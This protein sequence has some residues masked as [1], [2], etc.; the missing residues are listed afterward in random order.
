MASAWPE[1]TLSY[2]AFHLIWTLPVCLAL[3]LIN[4]PFLTKIDRAKLIL[5][6]LI[7]FVWTT[8]WD[9]LII[10]NQAWFYWR[11][12]VWFTIGYVPIEEYFFFI[13]QSIMTTLWCNL[14]TRWSM[15]NLYLS[16][17]PRSA[18]R[19]TGSLVVPPVAAA[20][21]VAGLRYAVPATHSYYMAMITWWSSIPLGLL[22]WG[23]IDFVFAMGAW[24]GLVPFGL[25]LLVPTVYLCAS[26]I[27]ALRRGTWHINER[28]S[29]NIFPVK[30]LPVE[31]M[32]FFLATNL[33]LV[34]ACFTFDRCVAIC[35]QEAD[36]IRPTTKDQKGNQLYALSPSYLPL[37]QFTTYTKLWQAFVSP[38][39][40]VKQ[41]SEASSSNPASD[42]RTS[43]AVLK[44][45][46]RSFNAA[47]LL[48]P[49]DL[50]TDLSS[51]YAFC[52][53]ADDL[54]DAPDISV[55]DKH[56]RLELV[57]KML[58]AI[59]QS[60]SGTRPSVGLIGKQVQHLVAGEAV[61]LSPQGRDE[62]RATACSIIPM[63]SIV[64]RRLWDELLRGY[65]IDLEF[66]QPPKGKHGFERLDD[67]VEY[68]Q[69]VAGCVGEMCTRV[70]MARGGSPISLELEVPLEIQLPSWD[71][72]VGKQP[73]LELAGT[74]AD[75]GTNSLRQLLYEAR[76]MGVSLQLVN[77]ARDIVSDSIELRRCYLPQE[78]LDKPDRWFKQSLL[79]GH[80]Q[81]PSTGDQRDVKMIH[82]A[83]LHKYSLR[84]VQTARQLYAQSFPALSQ[85]PNRPA[86]AGL[87]AACAVYAAIGESIERQP[88]GDMERGL[89]ARMNN[90]QRL[91]TALG[92][93]Y[94]AD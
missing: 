69:C 30:D 12:C 36:G 75:A 78:M 61:G 2:R 27:Y 5:L 58:D 15:P 84:L 65:Y 74:G 22:L 85:L 11:H 20:L 17:Q 87:R 88:T 31:E 37:N 57:S 26:D 93:I 1:C 72:K 42:L 25:S 4:R 29:F 86:R 63:A 40:P 66:E 50:R 92:A 8:P 67:L 18:R 10:H 43:L 24:H 55:E 51:L 14:M 64:P 82:P 89:R 16:T 62:L 38:N 53:V 60:P 34:T 46:S 79:D 83:E 49:W 68:S 70:I 76:K 41:N 52:R 19:A 71:A 56:R 94:S 7:A 9:N 81:L 33:L 48:L 77:I 39:E 32:T 54:V 45:A 91:R 35:R 28:T 6:P 47:S 13:I 3:F 23:T 44:R 73:S 59:Y 90:A 21:V 80:V